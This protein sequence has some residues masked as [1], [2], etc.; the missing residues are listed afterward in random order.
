[1]EVGAW[2]WIL[3]HESR[4]YGTQQARNLCNLL[5]QDKGTW[6]ALVLQVLLLSENGKAN[7]GWVTRVPATAVIPGAQVMVTIIGSK[8]S[9]AGSISPW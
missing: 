4:Y 5:A 9:V 2:R 6:S 1:M 7:K 8:A 3:R